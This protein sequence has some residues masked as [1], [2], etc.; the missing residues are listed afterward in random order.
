MSNGDFKLAQ[1]RLGQI[2][3]TGLEYIQSMVGDTIL[4][5]NEARINPVGR[6]YPTWG[7]IC[8]TRVATTA[9]ELVIGRINLA[10][11]IYLT[12]GWICLTLV[13]CQVS[14]IR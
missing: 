14:G 13:G 9:L 3:P 6:I 10:G 2:Y 11:Q 5:P 7:R 1:V 12:W 8:P 4:E